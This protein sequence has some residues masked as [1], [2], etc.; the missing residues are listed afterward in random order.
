MQFWHSLDDKYYYFYSAIQLRLLSIEYVPHGIVGTS[1]SLLNSRK[2][3][4]LILLSI[5]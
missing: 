3:V 4:R 2:R 5:Y 1:S